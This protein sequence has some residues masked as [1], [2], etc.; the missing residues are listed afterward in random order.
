LHG[1]VES[2]NIGKKEERAIVISYLVF[3]NS[4]DEDENELSL[5]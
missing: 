3:E 2:N 5:A 4:N 1:V